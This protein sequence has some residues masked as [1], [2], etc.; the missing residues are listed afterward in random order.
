MF[1][2]LSILDILLF[3]VSRPEVGVGGT[4]LASLKHIN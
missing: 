1:L 2:E 3:I 4:D